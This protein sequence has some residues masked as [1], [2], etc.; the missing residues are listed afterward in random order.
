M[1]VVNGLL[2]KGDSKGNFVSVPAAESGLSIQGE[3]RALRK[4]GSA[5]GRNMS[6]WEKIMNGCKY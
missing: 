4:I 1:Q 2:L 6:L 3:I 5:E